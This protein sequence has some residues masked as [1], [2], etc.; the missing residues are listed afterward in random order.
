M[1]VFICVRWYV[2]RFLLFPA[3]NCLNCGPT[4]AR[5]LFCA[6]TTTNQTCCLPNTFTTPHQPAKSGVHSV[7]PTTINSRLWF[8]VPLL[9]TAPWNIL[10]TKQKWMLRKL[11]TYTFI[12]R[13]EKVKQSHYRPGQAL[14]VQGVWG[15]QISR[16]LAHQG[17]KVVSPMHRPLYPQ[18]IFLILI[19]ARG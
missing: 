5:F 8:W 2:V 13:E 10:M 18:K 4:T 14:R 3:C 6:A 12:T 15:S 19:F 17:G 1:F 11:N 7:E 9:N 16:Q